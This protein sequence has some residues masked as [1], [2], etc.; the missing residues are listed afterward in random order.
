[1]ALLPNHYAWG[2]GCGGGGQGGRGRDGV[3]CTAQRLE[4]L[5]GHCGQEA[6][7]TRGR[8]RLLA[9]LLRSK[10]SRSM[11]HIHRG[12]LAGHRA[13]GSGEGKGGLSVWARWL[14]GGSGE[15]SEMSASLAV[16]R[17]SG[18]PVLEVGARRGQAP[19]GHALLHFDR[20]RLDCS[21]SLHL[22]GG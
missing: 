21:G 5:H 19:S 2:R 9:C 14:D 7:T 3:I 1:M 12:K 10:A 6:G 15:V 4:S 20:P 13:F 11:P 16:S 22:G 18:S 17:L 8:G